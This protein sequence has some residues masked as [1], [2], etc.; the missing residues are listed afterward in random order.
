MRF[1][2]QIARFQSTRFQIA[3]IW[4][5]CVAIFLA[6][7]LIFIVFV[8]PMDQ[9]TM[10][11]PRFGML[12]SINFMFFYVFVTRL[13]HFD[14]LVFPRRFQTHSAAWGQMQVLLSLRVMQVLLSVTLQG[15]PQGS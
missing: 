1:E 3:A 8:A 2:I 13:N 12:K 14:D 5:V 11:R 7:P 4:E 9:N 6:E 10:F 15:P